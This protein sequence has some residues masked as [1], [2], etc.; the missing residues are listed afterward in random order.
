MNHAEALDQISEIHKH[1]ARSEVYRGYRPLPV[2]LSGVLG[3][4]AAWLQAPALGANDPV[5]FVIYWSAIA[6]AAAAIGSSEIVFNYTFR[7]AAHERRKTRL[8]VAQFVPSVFAAALVTLTLVRLSA[9]LVPLLPGLWAALFGV[10]I[11]AARPYLPRAT[12]WVALFYLAA[13]AGLLWQAARVPPSAWTVGGTF[14]VG[15]LLAGLVLLRNLERR[16]E[17]S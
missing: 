15:Q 13:G 12:G 1:L 10:A 17:W 6:A 9:A 4:V 7:E 8:V 3:L 11:F 16:S 2:A 5:G 14:G